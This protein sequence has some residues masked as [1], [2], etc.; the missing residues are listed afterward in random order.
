MSPAPT[1]QPRCACGPFGP[2][3][4]GV[5]QQVVESGVEAGVLEA[6]PV[7]A[8]SGRNA[9]T[10]RKRERGVRSEN[11]GASPHQGNRGRRRGWPVDGSS[12]RG[13]ELTVLGGL[14]RCDMDRALESGVV[15][16]P[17]DSCPEVLSVD[18]ADPLSTIADPATEPPPRQ[19]GQAIEGGSPPVQDHP[20]S[21]H[22]QPLGSSPFQCALPAPGNSRHLRWPVRRSRVL[23]QYGVAAVTVDGQCAQLQPHRRRNRDNLRR[24]HQCPGGLNPRA[25]QQLDSLRCRAA[26]YQLTSKVDDRGPVELLGPVTDS[27]AIPEHLPKG[28]SPPDSS[29]QDDR[30]IPV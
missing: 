29:G 18:P 2:F 21:Q 27:L 23:G 20:G 12:Q 28:G 6:E 25:R 30:L 1:T 4:S 19:P 9:A 10:T 13:H 7:R 14:G 22:E 3:V 26:I 16:E 8:E 11:H 5:R 17:Q 24:R 15:Q